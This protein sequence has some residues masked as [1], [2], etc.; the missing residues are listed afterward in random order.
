MWSLSSQYMN[1][2]FLLEGVNVTVIS[3]VSVIAVMMLTQIVR[4]RGSIPH[5]GKEFFRIMSLI[6]LYILGE[7]YLQKYF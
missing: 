2:C 4:D 7:A 6:T 1:I 3:V 5:W